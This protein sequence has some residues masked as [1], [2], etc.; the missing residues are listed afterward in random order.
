MRHSIIFWGCILLITGCSVPANIALEEPRHYGG[1]NY[2]QHYAYSL[3]YNELHEQANWVAYRLEAAELQSVARRT[4]KFIEDTLVVTGTATNA[5][6]LRSGYDKGHLAPAADMAWD[7]RAMRESFYFSNIS[8][9][10][11]GFNRGVW[12]ELEEQV[13]AWAKDY[14]SLYIATGPYFTQ[15]DSAIGENKVTIPSHFYKAILVYNDTIQQ[16]I[17]F[18]FPHEKISGSFYDYML[19]VDELEKSTGIDF[20]SSLPNRVERRLESKIDTLFWK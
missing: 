15:N 14:K 5:D 17:A 16:A 10:L 13:R 7:E 1:E 19:T 6:Y 12:K 18:Y 2:I 11:P 9:Q 20:F 8:P 4:N 3:Q